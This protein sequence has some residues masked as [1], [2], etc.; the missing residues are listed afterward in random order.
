MSDDG[1][2]DE[3]EEEEQEEEFEYTPADVLQGMDDG[4]KTFFVGGF[5][6][7]QSLSSTLA[8]VTAEHV[9]LQN[10]HKNLVSSILDDECTLRDK[11]AWPP[12][13]H[14]K[15]IIVK[16]GQYDEKLTLADNN[17]LRGVC[18]VGDGDPSKVVV[19]DGL[20][21][22]VCEATVSGI[23]FVA[24]TPTESG[25]S[26][27][28]HVS[29]SDDGGQ[30]HGVL[31][32]VV[33]C[34]FKG[35]RT[36]AEFLPWTEPRITGCRFIGAKADAG[37]P[38]TVST[39]YCYAQ[40]R[41]RFRNGT[42]VLQ[43]CPFR[44]SK[45]D[46]VPS[47]TDR[48]VATVPAGTLV[49]VEKHE[50]GPDETK[51]SRVRWLDRDGFVPKKALRYEAPT[52][53]AV[54]GTG[55]PGTVGIFAD[56]ALC[57]VHGAHIAG[58]ETGAYLRE[59]CKEGGN[60][61]LR[62]SGKAQALL[63]S[64]VV[65]DISGSGVYCSDGCRAALR[66]TRVR[67][68]AHYT[69]LVAASSATQSQFSELCTQREAAL[70]RGD[71]LLPEESSPRNRL[72]DLN[73]KL[74]EEGVRL[75][76]AGRYYEGVRYRPGNRTWTCERQ[77]TQGSWLPPATSPLVRNNVLVGAVKVQSG[78]APSFFD[79]VVVKGADPMDG[80]HQG[81]PSFAVTGIRYVSEEPKIRRGKRDEDEEEG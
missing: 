42:A 74:S 67:R 23:T 69:L 63:H 15:L 1:D 4:P 55:A 22:A 5:S 78:A 60:R 39:V 20:H 72:N 59:P 61:H 7:L 25:K 57:E 68:C 71:A 3:A 70:L 76:D 13:A 27:A 48:P 10:W 2:R 66:N 8:R 47:A 38:A 65:E 81:T 51:W 58:H 36:V 18:I 9:Q 34:T 6:Q 80:V 19:K 73:A 75:E 41:P 54:H 37:V 17:A 35:G 16:E 49:H 43:A 28:L 77:A 50:T 53:C 56:D 21:L 24:G 79:N 46:K 12:L 32:D 44:V 40:S 31:A 14:R 62:W 52:P 29:C 30:R 64:C 11:R 26:C 45:G 33:N